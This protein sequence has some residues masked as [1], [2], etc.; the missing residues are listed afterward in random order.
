MHALEELVLL[1]FVHSETAARVP[2]QKTLQNQVF[3]VWVCPV[4][5]VRVVH[6]QLLV[7]DAL[8]NLELV[9][10]V[11]ERSVASVE[12]EQQDPQGPEVHLVVMALFLHDLRCQVLYSSDH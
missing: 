5:P 12:F 1:Q 4:Q 10:G 8:H 11:V 6:P 3:E 9:V 2:L 7:Y